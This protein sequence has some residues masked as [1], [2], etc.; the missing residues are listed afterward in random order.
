MVE[1]EK[2]GVITGYHALL[3]P[4]KLGLDH[5][6]FVEVKLNDTR[7]SALQAFNKEVITIHEI[8]Q[9]H[10]IAG[11]YDYLLKVRT[12][13]INDYRRV[14]GE[15]ISSLPHVASTSTFVS[16]QAVKETGFE[17]QS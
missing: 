8:E 14:L 9:C 3:D 4:I 11:N 1:L 13:S 17:G 6:A 15:V 12:Q 7:E 16:M 5:I 2:T 10:M